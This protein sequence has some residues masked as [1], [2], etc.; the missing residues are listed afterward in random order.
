MAPVVELPEERERRV[1]IGED[2]AHDGDV[3]TPA[4]ELFELL[5]RCAEHGSLWSAAA[6]RRSGPVGGQKAF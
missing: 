2:L 1:E 6:A 3:T 4:G 5:G